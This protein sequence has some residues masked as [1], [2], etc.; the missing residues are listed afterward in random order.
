MTDKTQPHYEIRCDVNDSV[1]LVAVDVMLGSRK[2]RFVNI[3]RSPSHGTNEKLYVK[4]LLN[5]VKKLCNV[6]CPVTVVGDL[7][8]P[9]VNWND[10]TSPCDGVQ[11]KLL[12]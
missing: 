6:K 3:Y 10:S 7:N 12:D 5:S 2:Y 9:D 1:E 11:D 8:C 4:E